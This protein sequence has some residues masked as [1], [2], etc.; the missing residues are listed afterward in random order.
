MKVICAHE[1]GRYFSAG[2]NK[3]GASIPHRSEA[4]SRAIVCG[5]VCPART[6]SLEGP[7][8]PSED[9]DLPYLASFQVKIVIVRQNCAKLGKSQGSQPKFSPFSGRMRAGQTVRPTLPY[10]S[11]PLVP[12]VP[13]TRGTLFF[14]SF[15][16]FPSRRTSSQRTLASKTHLEET[17]VQPRV[18]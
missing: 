16:L 3:A 14:D 2:D 18:P 9:R 13:R 8:F 15:F 4:D 12:R 10:A 6:G 11:I 7:K 17:I 5:N 1:G